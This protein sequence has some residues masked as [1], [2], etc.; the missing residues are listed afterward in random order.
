MRPE[1]LHQLSTTKNKAHRVRP[2]RYEYTVSRS[3]IQKARRGKGRYTLIHL[4]SR[5]PSR[6]PA[7]LVDHRRVTIDHRCQLQNTNLKHLCSKLDMDRNQP[8][9]KVAAS[10]ASQLLPRHG[11]PPPP[12]RGLSL[13][14]SQIDTTA[15]PIRARQCPFKLGQPYPDHPPTTTNPAKGDRLHVSKI[16]DRNLR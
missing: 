7:S 9:Q 2:F 4:E 10:A 11:Q 6:P 13:V 15:E 12:Y 5:G 3:E 1:Y 8:P 14:S 16:E